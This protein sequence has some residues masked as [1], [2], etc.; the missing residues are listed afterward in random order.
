MSGVNTGAEDIYGGPTVPPGKATH[1]IHYER[2]DGRGHVLTVPQVTPEVLPF[3]MGGD[4]AYTV[5]ITNANQVYELPVPGDEYIIVANGN[6][7]FCRCGGAGVVATT[8][9]GG[10]DYPIADAIYFRCRPPFTHI[11]FLGNATAGAIT[12]I[13]LHTP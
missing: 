3:F 7:A 10:Y 6:T 1:K 13:H 8:A 9:V 11:G 4:G 2:V 5:A 12:F